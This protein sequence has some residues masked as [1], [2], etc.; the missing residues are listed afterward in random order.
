MIRT[1]Q[2]SH[3]AQGRRVALVSEPH[4][5]MLEGCSTVYEL[6][7]RA[8]QTSQPLRQHIEQSQSGEQLNYDEVYHG[9]SDWQLLSPI[10]HPEPS[11]SFVTGTGLTHKGS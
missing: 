8:L 6:A 2:L 3:P 5:R 9:Q 10:D 1:V 11:R 4:L 7:Q